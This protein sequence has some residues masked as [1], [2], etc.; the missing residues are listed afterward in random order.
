M[1]IFNT[2]KGGGG[3][4]E[5]WGGRCGLML[6]PKM[7][8]LFTT[9]IIF[10]KKRGG[11]NFILRRVRATVKLSGLRQLRIMEVYILFNW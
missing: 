9:Y 3:G 4:R 11:K 1:Y 8:V 10:S 2:Q 7:S 5:G 6:W